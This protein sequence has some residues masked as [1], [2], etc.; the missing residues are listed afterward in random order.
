VARVRG[1]PLAGTAD[2]YIRPMR[3]VFFD[4]FE[5]STAV[6]LIRKANV[7]ILTYMARLTPRVEYVEVMRRKNL[8]SRPSTW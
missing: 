2:L 4:T 7:D 5:G 6:Y 3:S 1:Q 8:S